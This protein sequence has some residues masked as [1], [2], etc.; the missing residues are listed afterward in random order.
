MTTGIAAWL[1]GIA[2]MLVFSFKVLRIL[3]EVRT[4]NDIATFLSIV[5]MF[6][7]WTGV[8]GSWEAKV[9]LALAGLVFAAAT[10]LVLALLEDRY[11]FGE[12]RLGEYFLY[13]GLLLL[14]CAAFLPAITKNALISLG[15]VLIC[16][17]IMAK[18]DLFLAGAYLRKKIL[19]R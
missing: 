11:N 14:I 7:F 18:E 3:G 12:S 17:M 1:I 10:A 8:V 5:S 19:D 13:A 4:H 16:T 9:K 2:A 15:A 6:S